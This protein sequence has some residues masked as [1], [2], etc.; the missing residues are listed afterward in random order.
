MTV[1]NL[2]RLSEVYRTASGHFCS[3]FNCDNAIYVW[4]Q[5]FKHSQP[6]CNES[7]KPTQAWLTFKTIL[8]TDGQPRHSYYYRQWP[9]TLAPSVRLCVSCA[10]CQVVPCLWRS[11]NNIYLAAI[12]GSVNATVGYKSWHRWWVFIILLLLISHAF[13]AHLAKWS[14]SGK[15]QIDFLASFILNKTECS[16]MAQKWNINVQNGPNGANGS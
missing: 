13:L 16:T 12:V 3:N 11:I 5:L 10:S 7:R 8:V 14:P 6:G 15:T 9:A 1:D 2:S 4:C